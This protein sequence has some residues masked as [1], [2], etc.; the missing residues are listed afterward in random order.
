MSNIS[1]TA[2]G[3]IEDDT[4]LLMQQEDGDSDMDPTIREYLQHVLVELQPS[5]DLGSK[6]P[7]GHT[8]SHHSYNLAL[9]GQNYEAFKARASNAAGTAPFVISLIGGGIHV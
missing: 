3:A 4:E 6:A 8:H 9:Y 2:P 7:S 1:S 5:A